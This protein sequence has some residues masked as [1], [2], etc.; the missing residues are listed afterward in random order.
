MAASLALASAA[1]FNLVCLQ[2]TLDGKAVKRDPVVYRVDMDAGRYCSDEC[3]E[4]EEIDKVTDLE[5]FLMLKT[6]GRIQFLLRVNRESGNYVFRVEVG[7]N[8]PKP[9]VA[10]G[11]CEAAPFT[12]LPTRKF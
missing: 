5:L 6:T 12:G 9:I 2:T 1:A 4:S 10:E 7:P 3:L 8:D 11:H